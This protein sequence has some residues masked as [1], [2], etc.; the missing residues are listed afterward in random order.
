MSI[1]NENKVLYVL[2]LEQKSEY[3]VRNLK[4]TRIYEKQFPNTRPKSAAKAN[5]SE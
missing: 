3:S 4:Y 1:K 5:K 2:K